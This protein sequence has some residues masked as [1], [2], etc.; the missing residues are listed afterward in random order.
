[1]HIHALLCARSSWCDC[2]D[3]CH[4]V[5]LVSLCMRHVSTCLMLWRALVHHSRSISIHAVYTNAKPCWYTIAHQTW[6]SA[7]FLPWKWGIPI[8]IF[9]HQKLGENSILCATTVKCCRIFTTK[10]RRNTTRIFPWK[11]GNNF[12]HTWKASIE[13]KPFSNPNLK[14]HFT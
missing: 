7:R 14:A 3:L 1:M 9:S 4:Q 6:N 13:T 11:F 2:L 10:I 12:K 5:T 8:A